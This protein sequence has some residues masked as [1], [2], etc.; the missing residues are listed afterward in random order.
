MSSQSGSGKY[1]VD[2][3][4]DPSPSDSLTD[5]LGGLVTGSSS[6]RQRKGDAGSQEDTAVLQPVQEGPDAE[7]LREAMNRV[8][9]G[10]EKAEQAQQDEQSTEDEQ[11]GGGSTT[12]VQG[13][14]AWPAR[15]TGELVRMAWRPVHNRLGPSGARDAPLHDNSG[16]D[17][18]EQQTPAPE[19][20]T[21][22]R[23][24]RQGIPVGAVAVF[25]L[26]VIFLVVAYALV[27]SLVESIS[28]LFG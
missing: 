6:T 19:E 23:R 17:E 3:T 5:P 28:G 24:R 9:S 11:Q 7:A 10:D 15:P 4:W 14:R 27:S 13:R 8:L 1:G 2:G 12:R 25:V 26:G 21:G 16:T 22:W 18:P 20:R